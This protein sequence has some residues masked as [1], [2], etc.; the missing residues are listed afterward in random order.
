MFNPPV[1]VHHTWYVTYQAKPIEMAGVFIDQ[2]AFES[3]RAEWLKR[4]EVTDVVVDRMW[5]ITLAEYEQAV[6]LIR[7]LPAVQRP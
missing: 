4:I 2:A 3:S 6:R 5:S 7:G 1:I